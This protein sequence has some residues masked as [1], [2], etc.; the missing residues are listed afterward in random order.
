MNHKAKAGKNIKHNEIRFPFALAA[1]FAKYTISNAGMA[2]KHC[3]KTTMF[4]V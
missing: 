4:N 2:T 1:D 3:I